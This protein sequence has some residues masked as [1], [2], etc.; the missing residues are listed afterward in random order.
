MSMD[1]WE[2]HPECNEALLVYLT[3]HSIGEEAIRGASGG[4]DCSTSI[5][6]RHIIAEWVASIYRVEC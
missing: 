4:H 2:L 1:V 6:Q 5:A 3:E